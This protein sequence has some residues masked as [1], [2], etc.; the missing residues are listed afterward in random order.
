MR[1]PGSDFGREA[2]SGGWSDGSCSDGAVRRDE[3]GGRCYVASDR[4]RGQICAERKC[5]WVRYGPDPITNYIDIDI[6][7]DQDVDMDMDMDI[8]K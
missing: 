6:D 4:M 7:T 8:D 1:E 2:P 5:L 3:A